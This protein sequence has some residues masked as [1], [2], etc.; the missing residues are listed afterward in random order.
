MITSMLTSN[1]RTT[2]PLA[3]RRALRL[4]PGDEIG[5]R[6]EGERVVLTKTGAGVA[7]DPFGVFGEWVSEADHESYAEL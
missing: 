3:V 7:D 6:I 4:R 1:R 5:Y 2:I